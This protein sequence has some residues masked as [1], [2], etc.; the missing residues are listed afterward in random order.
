[1]KGKI[2]IKNKVLHKINPNIYGHFI[3]ELGECIHDGIWV[4][5]D[6][7]KIHPMVEDYSKTSRL[8]LVR[9]DLF[10]AIKDV[11]GIKN[12]Q[13]S[14]KKEKLNNFDNKYREN[15]SVLRWP[16]GCF[17][18]S[19]QWKNGIG[20]REQRSIS[21]NCQWDK[22]YINILP[23][24][25]GNYGPVYDNQFGTDEF[26]NFCER[27]SL[28]P[29]INI[30]YGSGS[31]ED[32][33]DW[34]EYVNGDKSTLWGGKRSLHREKPYNV[35]IW[36]IA[37]EIWAKWEIGHEKYVENYGNTYLKYATA[38]K[39]RDPSIKLVACGIDPATPQIPLFSKNIKEWNKDLLKI[40]GEQVD[41]ISCHLYLPGNNH[42]RYFFSRN[43]NWT[44]NEKLYYAM[45]ASPQMYES[46]IKGVWRDIVDVMGENTK[47]RVALDEWGVWYY[48]S[49]IIKANFMLVDGLWTGC[50]LNVLQKLSLIC[51]LAN[52]SQ[53]VNCLCLIRTD[54]EGLVLTPNYHAMK[55]YWNNSQDLL[56][57]SIIECEE[58]DSKKKYLIPKFTA[59]YLDV[60]VTM[61]DDGKKI[62]IIVINKHINQSIDTIL[63]LLDFDLENMSI[64]KVL[65]MTDDDPFATN[66]PDNRNRVQP[67]TINPSSIKLEKN[68]LE[69]DLKPH[70]MT[71]INLNL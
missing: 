4:Y 22:L 11:S 64:E 67:E 38:M 40:I 23:K 43:L 3:E 30:N 2:I 17:S 60:S 71:V 62:S 10:D 20:P 15:K 35:K 49:Q 52:Y 32:A 63:E 31:I 36:G 34:V 55:L 59:K 12:S 66:T 21:K 70:S 25:S 54:D 41:F 13:N 37:N 53:L 61:S 16:G 19:Y 57:E 6:K 46:M 9:K 51:P 68:S 14:P 1:M 27:L 42:F 56:L 47:I 65:C 29:Y 24:N 8:H 69:I 58:F 33:A 7:L 48:F 45:M 18:D 26:L 50:I 39:S 5:S 28:Q 44:K